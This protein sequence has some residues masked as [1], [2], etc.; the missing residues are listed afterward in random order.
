MLNPL[1]RHRRILAITCL[2]AIASTV[3]VACA[4]QT[5][6]PDLNAH[7]PAAGSVPVKTDTTASLSG[8]SD[9][10][11]GHDD[12]RAGSISRPVAYHPLAEARA[13]KPAEKPK[14]IS[15]Q[16]GPDGMV[17]GSGY[18][19]YLGPDTLNQLILNSD[20]IVRARLVSVTHI[21]EELTPIWDTQVT[22][23]YTNALEFK[24]DVLE[25]LYGSG[26]TRITA[27]AADQYEYYATKQE[28]IDSDSQILSTRNDA[29]DDREAILLLTN[30]PDTLPSTGQTGR[31]VL[32]PLRYD[33]GPDYYTIESRHSRRWYP[34][35]S[36][37][38]GAQ[39]FLLEAPGSTAAATA[40]ISLADLKAK[41]KAIKDELAGGDGSDEYIACVYEKYYEEQI[42]E[43]RES[44]GGSAYVRGKSRTD[45]RIDSG[46]SED[47]KIFEDGEG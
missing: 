34:A 3:A 25:Y 31:Y 7:V 20:A 42:A 2:M 47:S 28:V 44:W 36:S 40:T 5:A 46:L 30:N 38:A 39:S 26:E 4:P 29:W 45:L 19:P 41:T 37:G 32:G 33:F 16:A 11:A 24:F 15:Q 27:V 18:I 23:A 10:L 21:V 1:L 17:V 14:P 22:T 35:V 43:N 12:D 13:A 9:R 8:G 6:P